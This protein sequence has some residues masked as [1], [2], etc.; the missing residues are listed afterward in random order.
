MGKIQKHYAALFAG[1]IAIGFN[2]VLIKAAGAPGVVTSFYRFV[3][4][5]LILV[6]PFIISIKGNYRTLSKKG[7]LIAIVAG[8]CMSFDMSFWT[9]GIMMSNVAMPT[10][11]GNMASLW[12][13]LGAVVFFKERQG[14]LFWIGLIVSLTGIS[15]LVINDYYSANGMFMGLVF[16]MLAGMFYAT[17]MLLTQ[18]GRTYLDTIPYLFVFTFTTTIFLALFVF[19]LKLPFT[20]YSNYTWSLFILMGTVFHAGAWFLLNYS[21]GKIPASIVSPTLLLQ[22][23]IASTVAYYLLNEVLSIRQIVGGGVVISG[24]YMVHFSKKVRK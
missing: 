21:Q 15:L 6:V 19:I 3:F 20:G 12:V 23:L 22:P 1:A 17:F 4:G 18:K 14:I 2:P 11:T 24:I 5:T 9:T 16:G 10:L 7:L 8:L 13:G